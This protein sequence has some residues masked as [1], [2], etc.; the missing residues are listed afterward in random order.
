MYKKCPFCDSVLVY[1]K[2]HILRDHLEEF[3]ATRERLLKKVNIKK[4]DKEI[5]N[6]F[7]R[8]GAR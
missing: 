1:V 4:V 2:Q 7:L 5:I 3:N 6:I 8:K